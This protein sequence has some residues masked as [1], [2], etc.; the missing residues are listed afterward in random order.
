MREGTNKNTR[1]KTSEATSRTRAPSGALVENSK[2]VKFHFKLV[3]EVFMREG[4][5]QD[6]TR[7]LSKATSRTRAPSGALVENAWLVVRESE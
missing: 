3:P 4:T 2:R 1:K 7:Q 6:K 5:R